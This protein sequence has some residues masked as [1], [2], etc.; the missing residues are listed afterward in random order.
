MELKSLLV[1]LGVFSYSLGLGMLPANVDPHDPRAIMPG[2]SAALAILVFYAALGFMIGYVWTRLY[3]ARDLERQIRELEEQNENLQQDKRKL[4]QQKENL[5]QDRLIFAVEQMVQEGEL[6]GAMQYIDQ[7]LQSH[8]D[9]GRMTMTKARIL[10]RQATL[11]GV[12]EGRKKQL[13][14]QAIEYTNQAIRLLPG[15]PE[16]IYNK[17]CYQALLGAENDK[18]EIFAGLAKAFAMNPGLKKIAKE[19][20]DLKSIKDDNEFKN[21]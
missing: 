14:S 19:D 11:P 16:P 10:K 8:P 9:D 15:K 17:A 18:K 13:L 2:Q 20:D 4:E 3:F 1:H 7:A 6:N 21:F 5:E 12:D